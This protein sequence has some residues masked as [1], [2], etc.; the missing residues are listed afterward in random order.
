MFLD[1]SQRIR[2]ASLATLAAM[3][4]AGIAGA[5]ASE[6]LYAPA[7]PHEM[8]RSGCPTQVAPWAIPRNTCAY[9]GYYVG[10]G[11]HSYSDSG[12]C[13]DQGTWG[14]DYVG[15]CVT[16][17]VRLGWHHPPRAQGGTGSYEPDGPRL[18]SALH[19]D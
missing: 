19:H 15:R 5:D 10:G 2:R 16:P 9:S 4:I 8:S 11:A 7:S 6:S 13:P 17:I 3:M 1:F 14:W 18:R 12:R